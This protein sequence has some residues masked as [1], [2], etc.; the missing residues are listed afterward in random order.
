MI[1]YAKLGTMSAAYYKVVRKRKLPKIGDYFQIKESDERWAKPSG[2]MCDG[3]REVG[4]QI[5]YLL[6]RM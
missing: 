6:A 5:M 2:V 3:I 1:I 4:G